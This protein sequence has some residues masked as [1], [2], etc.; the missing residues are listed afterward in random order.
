MLLAYQFV[1]EQA[2]ATRVILNHDDQRGGGIF[3]GGCHVEQ[4]MQ[5]I[6]RQKRIADHHHFSAVLNARK[7]ISLRSQALFD[8]EDGKDVASSPDFHDES[9]DHGE[10][11]WKPNGEGGSLAFDGSNIDF[12]AEGFDVLLHDVHPYAATGYIGDFFCS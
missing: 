1:D 8:A 7:L 10:R 4:S 6:E 5:A 11:Q 2:A 12:T 3:G 9:V